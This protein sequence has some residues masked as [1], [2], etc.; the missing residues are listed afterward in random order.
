MLPACA[1]SATWNEVHQPGLTSPS[2]RGRACGRPVAGPSS[3]TTKLEAVESGGPC[4]KPAAAA[5]GCG[6]PALAPVNAR[7]TSFAIRFIALNIFSRIKISC[8][9]RRKKVAVMVSEVD[10]QLQ[11]QEERHTRCTCAL[12]GGQPLLLQLLLKLLLLLKEVVLLLLTLQLVLM[13]LLFELL[14][15]MSHPALGLSQLAPQ[16]LQLISG[17][18]SRI[19]RGLCCFLPSRPLP[20]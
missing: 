12:S 1:C 6:G 3:T 11:V 13:V 5:A 8:G 4:A 10:T 15:L 9:N 19:S 14:L 16:M 7:E 2:N 20:C 17:S 18:S